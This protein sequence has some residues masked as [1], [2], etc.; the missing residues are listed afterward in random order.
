QCLADALSRREALNSLALEEQ[1]TGAPYLRPLVLI[2]SEPRR[3]GV[4]TLDYERVREELITNHR[5]PADEIV[6]VTGDEKGLD[7]ID[8][9]YPLGIADP[10]CPVKF[11]ITQK[12]LAEGW[13]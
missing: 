1:R 8:A 9:K 5:I 6:V 11:I 4:E 13:D 7:E 2:Q 10:A 12:A 3:A